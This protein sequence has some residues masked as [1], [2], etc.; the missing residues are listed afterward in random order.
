MLFNLKVN[1]EEIHMFS[2]NRLKCFYML[3]G[4]EVVLEQDQYRK[5]D[6]LVTCIEKNYELVTS[7]I[8]EVTGYSKRM[9]KWGKPRRQICKSAC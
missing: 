8:K 4:K 2:Y 9:K 5:N 6:E 7:R 1:M 3:Q